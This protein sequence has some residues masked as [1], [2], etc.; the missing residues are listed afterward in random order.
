M[1]SLQVLGLLLIVVGFFAL[2]VVVKAWSWATNTLLTQ[3]LIVPFG[4]GGARRVYGV[5]SAAIIMVGCALV[6]AAV[7]A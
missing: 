2:Y 4:P 7:L 1:T 5:I 6:L 3:T